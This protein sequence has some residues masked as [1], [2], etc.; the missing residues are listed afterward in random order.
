MIIN[1]GDKELNYI[2]SKD[3][4]LGVY[5]DKIGFITIE[6]SGNIY[7]DLVYNIIGQMLSYKAASTIS[8]RF[9]TL[10]KEVRPEIVAKISNEEIKSCGLSNNKTIAIKELSQKII[11]K[12]IDFEQLDELSNQDLISKLKKIRGVGTWTAEMIATFTL[13]RKNI[14]SY[15]DVALKNGLIRTHGYKTLS[16]VRF[17]RLRRLYSPYCT[18]AALYYYRINDMEK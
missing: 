5:I 1:Y 18:I 6:T 11:N 16:K 15:D 12:E 4:K 9:V 14:F 2:K 7:D 17:E 3:P 8:K 13:G 10:V